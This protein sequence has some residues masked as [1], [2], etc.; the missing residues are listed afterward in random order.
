MTEAYLD[1]YRE[2]AEVLKTV[3]NI[4]CLGK[5]SACFAQNYIAHKFMQIP[6]IH[7]AGY[8]SAEFRHGPI[9]ILD[10]GT[11]SKSSQ[12]LGQISIL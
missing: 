7:A 4:F 5:G 1:K 12:G 9:A 2:I 10:E 6:G 11:P 8:S 3:Q